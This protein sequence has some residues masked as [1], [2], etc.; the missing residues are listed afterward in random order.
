VLTSIAPY[1]SFCRGFPLRRAGRFPSSVRILHRQTSSD[2]T[3]FLSAPFLGGES[4]HT[5]PT[6]EIQTVATRD[7]PNCVIPFVRWQKQQ[8]AAGPSV[9]ESSTVTHRAT[10]NRLSGVRP[11]HLRRD[12]TPRVN[13]N[14]FS[15]ASCTKPP[16]SASASAPSNRAM[17]S[18]DSSDLFAGTDRIPTLSQPCNPPPTASSRHARWYACRP[19]A[20]LVD[21]P[22]TPPHAANRRDSSRFPANPKKTTPPRRLHRTP[23]FTYL[24]VFSFSTA[25]ARKRRSHNEVPGATP[26]KRRAANSRP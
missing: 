4:N 21:Y 2:R 7:A 3:E 18:K 25:P 15:A 11:R 13:S 5:P 12:L 9:Q 20:R 1:H 17:S 8:P 23:P 19:D 26:S 16:S 10:A 22:R 24:H 6:L 14:R